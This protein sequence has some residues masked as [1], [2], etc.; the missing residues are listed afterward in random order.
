MRDRITQFMLGVFVATFLYCLMVLRTIRGSDQDQ[1]VPQIAVSM[2]VGLAL[3]SLGVLIYFIHHVSVS[4]HISEIITRVQ[5]D[6]LSAIDSV[7]PEPLG[8]DA[9]EVDGDR[10]PNQLPDGFERQSVAVPAKAAGYLKAFDEQ[11][12]LD[13]AKESD[14]VVR[15]DTRPGDF[16]L[17]NQTLM[18]AYPAERVDDEVISRLQDTALIGH[19][20]TPVQDVRFAFEQQTD[21][22]IRALSPGIND[23]F[24]AINCIDRLG[25]ALVRMAE[26]KFPSAARYDDDKRLRVVAAPYSFRMVLAQSLG[27]VRQNARQHA[28]VTITILRVIGRLAERAR[29]KVDREALW[30]Q[31]G[32]IEADSFE[33][34]SPH[35][36]DELRNEQEQVRRQLLATEPLR[37]AIND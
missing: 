25:E 29:R 9:A 17:C 21:L 13:A 23:P 34:L 15:L 36:L 3:F 1:F 11:A 33:H 32:A 8:A 35:D 14:L 31:V 28:S 37:H 2:G 22:A 24:T 5:Q 27:L 20:R 19:R 12:L 4:I 6:L 7:F 18:L 10:N 26:R 30:Q 16:L